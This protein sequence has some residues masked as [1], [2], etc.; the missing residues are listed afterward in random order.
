VFP[1][2]VEGYGRLVWEEEGWST[3][4]GVEV[5]LEEWRY[6]WRVEVFLEP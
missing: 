1:G 3:V 6:F 2:Y 5:F 4:K